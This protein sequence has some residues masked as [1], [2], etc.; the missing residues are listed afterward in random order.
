MRKYTSIILFLA[1]I[2]SHAQHS[3]F[4]GNNNYV[5]PIAVAT[6][7]A[8]ALNFNTSLQNYA[9]LP[10]ATY[11]SGD[12]TIECWVKPTAYT[13]WSRIIDFGNG[14]GSNNVLLGTSVGTSGKPGFY[15]G[16]AQFQANDQIPLNQWSHI[17]ATL[18]GTTATI[19]INGV[20]SGSA[21]FPVPANVIRNNNYIGR[22][23][24]GWGDPAP[25]ASFDDLRIWNVAK[26]GSEIQAS[27]NNELVGS[28]SGLV[29]YF[30][31]NEGVS[32][33]SN[34]A[35][36]TL[37]NSAT[38]TGSAY[39]ATLSGFKLNGTCVSNFVV[40]KVS[41]SI[42]TGGLV[43]NL[44]ASNSSSYSGTGTA[45]TDLSGSS[46]N[47][48]LLNG[49]TFN[50]ANGGT[51]VFDG[52]DDRV[53]TNY[54]PTF[55]DF[56]VCVWYKDNGSST[57]GRLVDNNYINGFWLGKNGTTPNQWGGGIKESPS[58]FGIYLTLPDSQ[59]HFLTS[60]RSGTTHTIYGDGITNKISNTVSAAALSG[61][62][63]AIGE[64]SGGGTGQIFKGNIP[65]V[66]IY[67][68][69]ITEA[70]I[71]QIFNATKGKYGL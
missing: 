41:G 39:N 48:T 58:P 15:V 62:S 8:N 35:I 22:S 51:M 29:A 25:S 3:F 14:A 67:S 1:V 20:A 23:N 63:I 2:V 45:W 13:N 18:S 68:R 53:Q 42:A 9:S 60:V 30:K 17:A 40:G 50:S 59:W 37:V 26:T 7:Q 61:T 27:M 34:T 57:Y 33:G 69:A 66:L 47:G 64:W 38:S 71:M 28:E 44:D 52:N 49:A 12:L 65:Q 19:Y 46:N 16:G 43:L 10:A 21:N 4:R 6:S 70:E 11:F 55:T 56:T 54:N 24:W 32:C 5:A 36:T 31:F